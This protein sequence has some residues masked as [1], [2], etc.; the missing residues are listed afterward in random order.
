MGERGRRERCKG[1]G[2]GEGEGDSEGEGDGEDED[3]GDGEGKLEGGN[4]PAGE[5]PRAK[6]MRTMEMNEDDIVLG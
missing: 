6:R 2:K 5:A 4:G 1:E 3:E